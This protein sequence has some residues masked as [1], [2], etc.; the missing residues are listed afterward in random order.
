M[1]LASWIRFFRRVLFRHALFCVCVSCPR[2]E[3]TGYPQARDAPDGWTGGRAACARLQVT[4]NTNRPR[5]RPNRQDDHQLE[6]ERWP[7][8]GEAHGQTSTTQYLNTKARAPPRPART[9]LPAIS[10]QVAWCAYLPTRAGLARQ[11][12]AN[13][14]P[15]GS[16]SLLIGVCRL[17]G[18]SE[19]TP[20]HTHTS[21]D[22]RI[23]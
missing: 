3:I 6:R 13:H 16:A 17:G 2:A 14:A 12:R 21:D 4:V 10:W 11:P 1:V 7:P 23:G 8:C 5:R 22:V 18:L 19:S 15:R 9:T 20:P